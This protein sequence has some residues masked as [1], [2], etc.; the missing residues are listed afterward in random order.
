MPDGLRTGCSR[1][2]GVRSGPYSIGLLSEEETLGVVEQI[3]VQDVGRQLECER[4]G[5][6]EALPQH[7]PVG[8]ED[9][10]GLAAGAHVVQ[11]AFR[12]SLG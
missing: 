7:R 11:Q 12:Q 10:L 2:C 8:G 1:A 4:L 3:V 6:D 5:Y 9:H